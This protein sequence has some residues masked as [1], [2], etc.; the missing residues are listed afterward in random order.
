[1]ISLKSNKTSLYYAK[2]SLELSI[3][4]YLPF[5]KKPNL[6]NSNKMLI[7][8]NLAGKAINISRTTAPHAVSYPFSS[9]FGISH[10]HAVSLTFE[11]FLLFNY[12]NSNRS[13]SSFNLKN[14]YKIIFELFNVKN[15]NE[16]CKK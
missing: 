7:S 2:K 11:K 3:T 10:G 9:M 8:S 4:N 13:L 6:E 1:M 12:L 15:I 5:I 14:R 16:L